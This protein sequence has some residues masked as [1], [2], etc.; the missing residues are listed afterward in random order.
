MR[1]VLVPD[2]AAEDRGVL[3]GGGETHLQSAAL[4]R[5]GSR[6]PRHHHGLL[7]PLRQD[8]LLHE[9]EQ[10]L[11]GVEFLAARRLC[12]RVGTVLH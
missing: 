5:G 4:A 12:V 6:P 8:Q 10:V 3:V 11:L 2:P 7:L 1:L 9:G